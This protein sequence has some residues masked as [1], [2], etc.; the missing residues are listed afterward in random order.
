[1]NLFSLSSEILTRI[2][3]KKDNHEFRRIRLLTVEEMIKIRGIGA[4]ILEDLFSLL[5]VCRHLTGTDRIF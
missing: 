1:M 3:S 5:D 2:Q 4:A